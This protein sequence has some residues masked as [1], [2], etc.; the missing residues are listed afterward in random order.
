MTDRDSIKHEC[1]Q[2]ALLSLPGQHKNAKKQYWT[3]ERGHASAFIGRIPRA[4]VEAEPE[5]TQSSIQ[6]HPESK[7]F[8]AGQEASNILSQL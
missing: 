3:Q 2:E 5:P 6:A 1:T 4:S 8:I 7:D